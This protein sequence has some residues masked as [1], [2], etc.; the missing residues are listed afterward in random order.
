MSVDDVI[1]AVADVVEE[2]GVMH[3]TYF[4]YTSDHGYS[5]GELNLEWDKRNVY[6]FDTR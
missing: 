4:I 3:N 6:E 1:G 2:L 5:F